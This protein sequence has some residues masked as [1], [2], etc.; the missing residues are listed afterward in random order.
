MGLVLGHTFGVA[1]AAEALT[2]YP[3]DTGRRDSKARA[4]MTASR[5]VPLATCDRSKTEMTVAT[6]GQTLTTSCSANDNG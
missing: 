3:V 4:M 1:K 2:G 6:D 5:R